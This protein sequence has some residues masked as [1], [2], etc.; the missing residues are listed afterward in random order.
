MESI[1]DVE[2]RATTED[3][4]EKLGCSHTAVEN[5][6]HK[7]GKVYKF[8]MWVPHQLTEKILTQRITVCSSLLSRFACEPFLDR[9][10]T[11]DEKWVLYVNVNRKRQWLNKK[12]QPL[13]IPKPQLHPK[14]VMLC[15]WWKITGIVHFELLPNTM[16]TAQIYAD[17]LERVQA[18]LIQIHPTLVNRKG[19]IL[20]HNNARPHVAK[21]VDEKIMQLGWEVLAHPPYSPDLAPS[22]YHLFRSLQHHLRE[23]SYTEE[24]D[25]KMDIQSFLDSKS[26][27]FY[28][29]GINKLVEKWRYVVDNNGAYVDD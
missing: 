11:G 27:S 1:L 10:V 23:K 14:K 26:P 13:K 2:P 5:H 12:E 17:Q 4:A 7:M 3:I 28:E 18:S 22:D 24:D 21:L 9:I 8:G 20:L 29:S 6:L 25:I 15:V 19:V 16:V